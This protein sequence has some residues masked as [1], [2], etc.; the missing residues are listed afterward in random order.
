MTSAKLVPT[1]YDDAYDIYDAHVC[2]TVLP[3]ATA[4]VSPPPCN[5]GESCKAAPSPQPQIFG[6][7]SS[8][9]FKGTGNVASPSSGPVVKQKSLTRAQKL[10]RALRACQKKPKRARAACVRQARKRY[11]ARAARRAAAGAIRRNRG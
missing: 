2:T 6:A 8:A 1:D 11:G 3:C 9:T 4:P 10:A 7:P 5:S